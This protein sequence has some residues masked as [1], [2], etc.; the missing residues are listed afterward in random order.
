MVGG[1]SDH[2]SKRHNMLLRSLTC[3]SNNCLVVWRQASQYLRHLISFLCRVTSTRSSDSGMKS[4]ASDIAMPIQTTKKLNNKHVSDLN[5]TSCLLITTF[6]LWHRKLESWQLFWH[7]GA[8]IISSPSACRHSATWGHWNWKQYL[9]S[10]FHNAFES[11]NKR[12]RAL[13]T[14]FLRNSKFKSELAPLIIELQSQQAHLGTAVSLAQNGTQTSGIKKITTSQEG[15]L[16]CIL[17]VN[18]RKQTLVKVP[19]DCL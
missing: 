13:D 19:I 17:F 15:M 6:K 3:L 9:P 18:W 7:S 14:S 11:I 2:I 5:S 1:S 4:N 8:T 16:Y 12:Y 10:V